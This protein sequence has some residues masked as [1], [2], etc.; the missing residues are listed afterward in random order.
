MI[1]AR[2]ALPH[3]WDHLEPIWEALPVEVR[4]QV[5]RPKLGER[6]VRPD[7][8]RPVLVASWL[9]AQ[10]VAPRPYVYV[11]HGA[12]Q[13]YDG[14]PRSAGHPS[15]SGGA[16]HGRCVLFICPSVRVAA[17]WKARYSASGVVAAGSPTVEALAPANPDGHIVV[18]F[19]WD[20]RLVPETRSALGYYRDTLPAMVDAF[21]ED[22]AVVA[23]VHPRA[24]GLADRW[25][26]LGIPVLDHRTALG[27]A[28]LLVGDNT[29]AMYE[30]AANGSQVLALNAPWYRRDVRHGLRFWD[31][32]PGLQVD[33]GADLLGRW[34]DALDGE[35]EDQRRRA[36]A[37]AY[38]RRSRGAAATAARAIM[39]IL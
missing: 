17:R 15:Y 10:A 24:R 5:E 38:V 1:D 6:F 34:R 7:P 18:G 33:C 26:R 2:A 25:E 36:A 4:G 35:G 30:A 20:C 8:A 32:V 31:A 3:Y 9:D 19:H 22:R 39:G 29:S 16:Q 28:A 27:R 14:D 11:E 23:T 37:T 13:S 12:G 21:R